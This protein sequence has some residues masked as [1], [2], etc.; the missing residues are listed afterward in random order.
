MDKMPVDDDDCDFEDVVGLDKVDRLASNGNFVILTSRA[1][2]RVGKCE[3]LSRKQ[4]SW[5]TS[6]LGSAVSKA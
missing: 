1:A 2:L 4:W 5:P 3:I 6:L